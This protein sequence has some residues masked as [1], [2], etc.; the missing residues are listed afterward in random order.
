MNN[1]N[2]TILLVEDNPDQVLL[3][4]RALKKANVDG[5]MVVMADGEQ[6]LNYLNGK[7]GSE[8]PHVVL[9]DL[10]LPGIGGLEVLQQIRNSP[11]TRNLPVVILSTSDEVSDKR[12]GYA[13][14]ANSYILKPVEFK[15]FVHV[16]E[17][18]AEYWLE[19]NEH[20]TNK[21]N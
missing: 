16:V 18:L 19:L 17:R 5:N 13:I 8:L 6:A 7:S 11:Q 14:G 1:N 20:Y 12:D 4:E 3:A 21:V 15:R 10:G 2:K 9:L